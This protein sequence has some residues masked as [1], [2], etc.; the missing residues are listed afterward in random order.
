MFKR[1][2]D[3][4]PVLLLLFTLC[5]TAEQLI[6]VQSNQ[7]VICMDAQDAMDGESEKSE[8]S[9]EQDS[10]IKSQHE[11][12]LSWE[13]TRQLSILFYMWRDYSVCT[14]EIFSPP[15]LVS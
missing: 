2:R 15:E 7:E 13:A 6:H 3:L 8:K 1:L 12:E 9:A 10:K 11:F 14:E 5:L 4:S